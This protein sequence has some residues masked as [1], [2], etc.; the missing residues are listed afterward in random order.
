MKKDILLLGE[1]PKY[2]LDDT[3]IITEA[4]FFVNVTKFKEIYAFLYANDV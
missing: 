2:G 1:R 4:K 3:T